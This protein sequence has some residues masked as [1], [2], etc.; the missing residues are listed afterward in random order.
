[1]TATVKHRSLNGW[2]LAI[3]IPESD[4]VPPQLVIDPFGAANGQKV[5]ISSDGAEARKL[6]KDEL[7]PARWNVLGI[8]DS[9]REARK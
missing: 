1:M 4:D 6:V 7:S 2:R 3:A 5:I 8:I 9:A